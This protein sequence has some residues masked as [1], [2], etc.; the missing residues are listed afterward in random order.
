MRIKFFYKTLIILFVFSFFKSSIVAQTYSNKESSI[1]SFTVG[2][3]SSN[4]IKDSVSYKA[5]IWF[6]GGVA[7]S[8]MLNKH[9]NAEVELLYAGKSFK[10][11]SPIVKYRHYFVDI[12]LFAQINLSEN[13]RV[14]IGGQY[15]I[16]THS[17]YVISDTVSGTGVKSYKMDIL[18]SNDYGFLA[19]VEFD[20]N[21][22]IALGA[23]YTISGSTFFEKNAINFGVFQFSVKY[24]PIKTYKVFFGKKESQQ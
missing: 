20:L 7:Y 4:L 18:K 9:I 2:M 23:R 22:Q 5:G 17:K 8:V 16:A 11:E 6:N 3:T 1:F 21:S 15:S 24:S 13:I 19:G 10:T 12:P 14:N